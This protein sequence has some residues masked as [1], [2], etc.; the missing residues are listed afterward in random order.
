MDS[1]PA[2]GP[3]FSSD[4]MAADITEIDIVDKRGVPTGWRM[5]LAQTP[6]RGHTHAG[7]CLPR[8]HAR[9]RHGPGCVRTLLIARDDGSGPVVPRSGDRN[10]GPG[11]CSRQHSLSGSTGPHPEW[12][13]PYRPG[14][15]RLRCGPCRRSRAD[16]TGFR[17]HRL[18][19]QRR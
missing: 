13:R 8:H 14:S 2:D 7:P 11:W 10:V 1:A 18:R 4:L 16:V 5:E 17:L 19:H 12:P 15:A 9:R 3:E 6:T